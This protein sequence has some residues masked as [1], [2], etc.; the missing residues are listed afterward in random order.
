MSEKAKYDKAWEHDRYRDYSPGEKMAY[1]FIKIVK[2]K[3]GDRVL[4]IGSGTGRA[5]QI[6]HDLGLDVTL[7]D[8]SDKSLDEDVNLDDLLIV[9]DLREPFPIKT[10][11]GK[12]HLGYTGY[13]TDVMEHIPTEDVDKVL[14][15][16]FG[17]CKECFFQICF[18][19]D[20][21]GSEIGEELHLTVKPYLWWLEKLSQ[22]SDIIEARDLLDNGVFY[23]RYT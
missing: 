3:L 7:L 11:F 15:N 6:F 13:C 1:E 19:K 16:I 8:I 10:N 4:D 22:Y 20:H 9:C 14:E 23:V 21:F 5:S 17:V 18:R 12:L 2:P